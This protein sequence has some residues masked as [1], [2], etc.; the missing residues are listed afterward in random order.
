MKEAIMELLVVINK[1]LKNQRLSGE[2]RSLAIEAQSVLREVLK[3]Y[4]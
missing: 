4:V 3:D 1:I 2:S